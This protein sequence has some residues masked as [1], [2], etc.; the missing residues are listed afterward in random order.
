MRTSS[1]SGADE[2]SMKTFEAN[3]KGHI[4]YDE[5]GNIEHVLEFPEHIMHIF[6]SDLKLKISWEEKVK[7]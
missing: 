6:I 3:H 7:K 2:E 1:F 4:D 5:N